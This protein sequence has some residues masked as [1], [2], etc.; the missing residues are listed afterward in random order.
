M[1]PMAFTSG[2][3]KL[4]ALWNFI[5]RTMQATRFLPLSDTILGDRTEH[6]VKST[7]QKPIRSLDFLARDWYD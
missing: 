7:N 5:I 1:R 4:E 6:D 3:K 2:W